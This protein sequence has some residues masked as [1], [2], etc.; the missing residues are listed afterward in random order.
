LTV[1][2]PELNYRASEIDSFGFVIGG[3]ITTRGLLTNVAI[4]LV[5]R[6]T[7]LSGKL[8]SHFP[9]KLFIDY[10]SLKEF[11]LAPELFPAL[12]LGHGKE[13]TDGSVSTYLLI[14]KPEPAT[15]SSYLRIGFALVKFPTLQR[16][17]EFWATLSPQELHFF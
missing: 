5:T 11:A 12:V 14:L 6:N 10:P 8:D 9:L 1:V 15:P 7:A 17:A 3:F 16:N 4:Q 2:K 13:A